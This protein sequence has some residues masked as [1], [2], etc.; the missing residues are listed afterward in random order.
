MTLAKK[1][2][3]KPE[4]RKLNLSSSEIDRLFAEEKTP[5]NGD[6]NNGE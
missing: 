5:E 1:P 2:W 6:R 3:V 4:V